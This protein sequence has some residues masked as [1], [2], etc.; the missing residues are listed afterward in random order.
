MMMVA[1]YCHHLKRLVA[2]QPLI[3]DR[4]ERTEPVLCFPTCVRPQSWN[5]G[6][7]IIIRNYGNSSAEQDVPEGHLTPS[8]SPLTPPPPP[9]SLN[10]C[11]LF[12]CVSY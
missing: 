2:S 4:P 6:D 12:M 9:P 10:H 1:T 8:P 7:S 3:P 11:K 5:M